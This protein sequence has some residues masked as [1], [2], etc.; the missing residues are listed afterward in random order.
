[1]IKNSKKTK[2][3]KR[4]KKAEE[5]LPE[6]YKECL[7]S[8]VQMI[9]TTKRKIRP[10]VDEKTLCSLFGEKR[11]TK[12]RKTLEAVAKLHCPLKSPF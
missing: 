9:K 5:P 11:P 10:L 8:I 3:I 12:K 2:A 4:K 1:M 7:N 6:G